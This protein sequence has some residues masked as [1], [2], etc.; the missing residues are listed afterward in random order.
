VKDYASLSLSVPAKPEA[1][2]VVRD[3]L[4]CFARSV[5]ADDEGAD[6]I[7]LAAHEAAANVVEHAYAEATGELE[8]EAR[9]EGGELTIVVSDTTT[10]VI[11]DSNGHSPQLPGGTAE[12]GRGLPI[13]KRLAEELEVRHSEGTHAEMTF[14]IRSRPAT[15]LAAEL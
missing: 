5:G 2:P 8:V 6:A 1:L 13:I 9:A 11:A 10:V 15:P 3:L 12:N 7:K 4:G 14:A